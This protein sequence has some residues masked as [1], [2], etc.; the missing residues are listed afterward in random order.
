MDAFVVERARARARV[1]AERGEHRVPDLELDGL[2]VNGDH[3]GSKLH[4]CHQSASGRMSGN[5]DPINSVKGRESDFAAGN[6][7]WRRRSS[8]W[9]V[10]YSHKVWSEILLGK[11][12]CEVMH[13]LEALVGELKQQAGLAHAC[14][15]RGASQFM[16]QMRVICFCE[17]KQSEST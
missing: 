5:H 1:A 2:A 7:L 8:A 9:G 4:P 15:A 14:H 10:R 17:S 16:I 12:Y 11:T 3:T 13:R 6:C